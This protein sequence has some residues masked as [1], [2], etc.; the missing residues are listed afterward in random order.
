MTQPDSIGGFFAGGSKSFS[1]KEKPIGTKVSGIIKMVHPP[2]QATDPIDGSPVFNKK[3]QKPKMQV[4]IDLDTA[5]RD[6]SDPD[7]DGARALY[8]GGWMQGAVGDALRKAGSNEPKVGG[9]LTVTLTERTP[10]DNPAMNP[11]NKFTAAYEP[12]AVTGDYF[13][14]APATAANGAAPAAPAAA[15]AAPAAPAAAGP[16]RPANIPEAAWAAM[17][18]ATQAIVAG[19]AAPAAEPEPVKPAA[20]SQQAWDEMPLATKKT[21]AA[22]MG[23]PIPY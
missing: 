10:N 22:T 16:A 1:W 5:E 8:V 21:V 11:I 4:R 2:Q 19:A 6:P 13:N 14:G 23:E 3:T 17:D 7:D 12:P 18:P 9:R 15:P 20:I